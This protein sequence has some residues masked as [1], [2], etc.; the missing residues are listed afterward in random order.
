[1]ALV[2]IYEGGRRR[3]R[4]SGSVCLW[5]DNPFITQIFLESVL[6]TNSCFINC[7]PADA[8][9]PICTK[10]QPL[11]IRWNAH[12][13]DT[14]TSPCLYRILSLLS[15]PPYTPHE[16]IYIRFIC[17]DFSV[18]LHKQQQNRKLSGKPWIN[19]TLQSRVGV[20]IETHDIIIRNQSSPTEVFPEYNAG[21]KRTSGMHVVRPSRINT[22][23]KCSGTNITAGHSQMKFLDGVSRKFPRYHPTSLTR[24]I[25]ASNMAEGSI[26]QAM[27]M[28]TLS[29]IEE[30]MGS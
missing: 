3:G 15:L 10:L 29:N 9:C 20:S 6:E 11:D 30:M 2:K 5:I 23:Q 14:V 1:M 18:K 13:T 8:R 22:K 7:Y 19:R 27:E 21:G 25:M 28:A 4:G 16:T 12:S 17:R 24:T 26:A